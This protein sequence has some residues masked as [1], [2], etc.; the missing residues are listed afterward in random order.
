MFEACKLLIFTKEEH[1]YFKGYV[2]EFDEHSLIARFPTNFPHTG[3]K[4]VD[5]FIYS[6]MRGEM[7]FEGMIYSI[8]RDIVIFKGLRHIRT[9][10]KRDE[11]RAAVSFYLSVR[12]VIKGDRSHL[13]EGKQIRFRA[14]NLSAGG[15]LL[16]SLLRIPLH[17]RFPVHL[18]LDG[19]IIS[20]LAEIVRR[21]RYEDGFY[22]GCKFDM[23]SPGD[24]M[25]IR[26][27]VFQKQIEDKQKRTFLYNSY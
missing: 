11:T 13:L 9:I 14:V 25:K 1:L 2:L 21:E 4:R 3:E 20:C 24:T 8:Y 26:R 16:H 18:S 5:V 17:L 23:L 7:Q 15:I 6:P 10:Q 22:Y 12:N 19:E 27:F